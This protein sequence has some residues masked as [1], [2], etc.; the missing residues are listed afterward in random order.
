MQRLSV[1]ERAGSVVVPQTPVEEYTHA[2]GCSITGGYV[3][4]GPIAGI[5][6]EYFYSDYCQGW[7][8]SFQ[9]NG[10][11]QV[12]GRRRWEVGPLGNVTS[13][14]VDAAGALYVLNASGRVFLLEAR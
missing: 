5:R 11:G 3:Y 14:G 13:F 2:D 9:L 6:G 1:T 12:V 8:R 10:D 4:R 7:L